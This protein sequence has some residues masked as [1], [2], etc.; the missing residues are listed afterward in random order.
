MS[1]GAFDSSGPA[2]APAIILLHGS[3]ET[4]RQWQPQA[5]ALSGS[6]HVIAPDLP[7]HGALLGTPFRMDAVL[8]WLSDL[9]S[10]QAGGRAVVAGISLGGYVTME[11]AARHP[12]QVLGA[13][14]LS[15]TAEPTGPGAALFLVA[16]WFM[17]LAPLPLL[18]VMKR[19]AGDFLYSPEAAELLTGFSFRGGAQGIRSVLWRS[20]VEKIRSYPGPVLFINGQRDW[21]FRCHERRFLAAA[22][23]GRLELIPRAF[24][25]CN[26]DDPARVTAL[27]RDF[28]NS[29]SA[30]RR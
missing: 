27:I 21:P 12:E 6:F 28:A 23:Q 13:I 5:R 7:A 29:V 16:T 30:G 10:Q 19:V 20:F 1:S 3:S 2:G 22:R 17:S 15:C 26:L 24:H 14:P 25:V 4:R 18:R 11:F 9:I 8:A